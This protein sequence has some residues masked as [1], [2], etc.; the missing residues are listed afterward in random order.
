MRS[1]EQPNIFSR[2]ANGYPIDPSNIL[3]RFFGRD[4]KLE[5]PEILEEFPVLD[6]VWQSF[7]AK[8]IMIQLMRDSNYLAPAVK[9]R[10]ERGGWFVYNGVNGN[11][12]FIKST[13]EGTHNS[14]DLGNPPTTSETQ[15]LAHVHTHPASGD[16]AIG[17]VR[18]Q[19]YTPSPYD[20]A[21][22]A[23]LGIPG[24]VVNNTFQVYGY[25]G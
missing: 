19:Y 20:E 16:R 9:S 15:A 4:L 24:F 7:Y 21:A 25:G 18:S 12:R 17:I 11:V 8:K 5:N 2:G 3:T 1:V 23:R 22:T 6:G 14:V 13:I 10:T